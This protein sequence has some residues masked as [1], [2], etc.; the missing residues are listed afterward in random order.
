M[1]SF[2]NRQTSSQLLDER[3]E[4]IENDQ[5]CFIDQDL[6]SISQF[7]ILQKGKKLICAL[8]TVARIYVSYKVQ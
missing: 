4:I 7:W 6:S 8:N 1:T 2:R 5:G 3:L